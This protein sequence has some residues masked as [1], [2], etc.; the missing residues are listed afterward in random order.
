MIVNEPSA[1][2]RITN[3]PMMNGTL[4]KAST[5]PLGA[6]ATSA[7]GFVNVLGAL[8]RGAATRTR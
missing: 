5:L 4:L 3:P 2:A 1:I 7:I 8:A 6:R